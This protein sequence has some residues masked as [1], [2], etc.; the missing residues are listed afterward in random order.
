[1]A[2]ESPIKWLYQLNH[3]PAVGLLGGLPAHFKN[4]QEVDGIWFCP[5]VGGPLPTL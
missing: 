2:A 5:E 3:T 1:M 4:F